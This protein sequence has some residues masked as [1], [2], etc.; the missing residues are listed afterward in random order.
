MAATMTTAEAV[1][2]LRADP[3]YAALV[4][5][6]YLEENVLECAERF[7]TSAEFMEVLALLDGRIAGGKVL[8]LGAGTGIASYALASYGGAK[9]VYALEPDASDEVG[10]GAIRQ[11]C[12]GLPIKMLETYGERILLPDAEVDV[13]YARQVLHHVRDLRLVLRE[14]A[15]VLKSGGLFL[16]CREHVIDN[17][18]ELRLFLRDHPVHRLAGGENAFPLH[19]Y[20][21]AIHRS[22]L[23]LERVFDP[24]DTVINLFPTVRTK[25]ELKR[26]PRTILENR[27]GRAG[28]LASLLPGANSLVWIRIRRH[29]VP[30]RL[31]SFLAT[32]P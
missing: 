15:R 11:L 8:D 31:Y 13:V 30:G 32:K 3:E 22:G 6:S 28:A 9:L 29:K 2:C 27:F 23:R 12:V 20:L 14:C 5:D 24:W 16:A 26:F 1:R 17:D 19:T 4:R 25:A 21:S 10:R 18:E 7:R